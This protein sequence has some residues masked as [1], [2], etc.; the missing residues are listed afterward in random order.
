MKLGTLNINRKK[1]K[2]QERIDAP[3]EDF[4]VVLSPPAERAPKPKPGP[5]PREQTE[6]GEV[7]RSNRRAAAR[8]AAEQA[9]LDGIAQEK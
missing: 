8:A 9:R 6:A 2:K 7:E 4:R 5:T 1:A 3:A